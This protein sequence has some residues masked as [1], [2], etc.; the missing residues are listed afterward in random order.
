MYSQ[1]KKS[2]KNAISEALRESSKQRLL[3]ELT[4]ILQLLAG[5][6]E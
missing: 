4:R 1:V 5:V 6:E 2:D 3:D